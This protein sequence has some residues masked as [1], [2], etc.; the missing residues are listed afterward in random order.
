MNNCIGSTTTV[1]LALAAAFT[2]NAFTS[3]AHADTESGEMRKVERPFILWTEQEAA[4]LRER[5]ENDPLAKKQYER[6][7]EQTANDEVGG[8]RTLR[9]LFNY[10]V[11]G[12]EAAGEREKRELLNFIDRKPEP[13]TWGIDE[14]DLEWH[15]GGP[16][17]GDRHMRDEQTLNTLRYD[18]FYHELSD[19]QREGVEEAMRTYIN[20]HLGGHQPWH[21][22]FAYDRTSWLPNMHWPRA[23]GTH[24]MA[25]ALQDE[26][27]IRKMFESQG[28]FKWYFD[29]YLADGRFY[30]E[31]F[32]KHYS[33]LGTKLMY[34]EALDRLGLGQYGY[35]YEGEGGAT[36]KKRLKM[37]FDISYPRLEAE[38]GGM[39]RYPA[40][41]MGDA[42]DTGFVNGYNADGEGGSRWWSHAHMNG[43]LPKMGVPGWFEIAHRRWPDAHF[44]YFLAQL[45]QPGDEHYYPSP[46]FGLEPIEPD[47]VTPP[48]AES[49]VTF[50]RGFAMLRAEHSRDYWESASPAVSL[51]FAMYYVHYVSDCFAI[52]QYV[53]HN[54]MLYDRMG[55]TARGYAGGDAWRD[56]VRG[57]S[58]VVVDGERASWVDRGERGV[59]NHRLR[60][61]LD[62]PVRFTS[63]GAEGV[64]SDV[65]QERALFLTDEYLFDVFWLKSDQDEDRTFDWQVLAR[66]RIHDFDGDTWTAA[67]DWRGD[68][69]VERPHLHNMKVKDPEDQPWVVTVMQDEVNPDSPREVGVRIRMLPEAGTLV[70]G[71][72]PPSVDVEDQGRS[73]LVTRKGQ[74]TTFAALHEPFEGGVGNHQVE[75]FDRIG[76]HDG[77]IGA[78]IVGRDGSGINDRLLLAWDETANEAVTFEDDGERFTFTGHGFLRIG[79]DRI[80]A[81]G[82]FSQLEVNVPGEPELHLNGERVEAEVRDGRLHWSAS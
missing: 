81:T 44:D 33:N 45:R 63:V 8:N 55:R 51:Q 69:K 27:L 39:P 66:G 64:Y 35:D 67:D 31:E 41:T 61:D 36:V 46:Y 57:H 10:M 53:S 70:L 47:E 54:R 62:G 29:E 21:P 42:G 3:T 74:S 49:Y 16:S 34:C 19:E 6:M 25:V 52:M 15:V 71:S 77:A 58:G 56:H 28:G 14:D 30:M 59:E 79:E 4:E 32:G 24:L 17:H 65:N 20:F 11:M 7:N 40:V 18:V 9:N 22:D 43:P 26:E 38:P 76:Q 50:E 60:E 12:D 2:L 78:R 5:I 37:L 72:V 13:L 68:R 82:E 73:V 23:I 1:A 75:R 80:E 48:P